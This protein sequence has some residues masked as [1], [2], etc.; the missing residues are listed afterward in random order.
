MRA[1]HLRTDQK[2]NPIGIDGESQFLSWICEGGK[3]QTSY[4]IVVY[5][6]E[7]VIFDSGIVKSADMYHLLRQNL[8]GRQI[9]AWRVRLWDETGEAGEW[10]EEA[11]FEMG[12]LCREDWKA[13][14]INPELSKIKEKNDSC[15]DIMNVQAKA[16]WNRRK[17]KGN[18]IP[19]QPAS[20][21]R[22]R[23]IA[24][25]G[26][27]K[28]LYITCHGLYEG[29]LNGKRLGNAVLTPGSSNYRAE[30]VYQTYDL[31]GLLSE[32]ENELLVVLGDGW[33]RSTTGVDGDRNL[34][35]EEIGLFCQLEVDE[36][37]VLI[38]DENWEAS[39]EGPLRQNDMRQGS[40]RCPSRTFCGK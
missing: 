39:Q 1:I 38:S 26:K 18:Y 14:W 35:G 17:E 3:R 11:T 20:Y 2:K 29:W 22:Y 19:H 30:L 12:L 6:G 25:K 15:E 16:A 36:K 27:K 24:P 33:Y 13:K 23:F 28:R 9:V 4:Q 21:L 7:K 32:G 37:I 31:E 34:F 5:S 40:V 8:S 10:S